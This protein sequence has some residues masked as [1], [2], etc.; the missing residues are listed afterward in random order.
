M[1][2]ILLRDVA[3]IGKKFEIKQVADGFGRNFLLKNGLATIASPTGLKQVEKLKSQQIQTDQ[4][5]KAEKEA[6]EKIIKDQIIVIKAKANKAG[7][8]FAGLRKTEISKTC[9]EQIGKKINVG[10]LIIEEPIKA[11]GEYIVGIKNDSED[12]KKP[13]T[14]TLKVEAI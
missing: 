12:N 10:D 5:T 13:S 2:V 3:K 7:H 8:L 1:K 14:F 4:L 11:I 6:F 9:Q